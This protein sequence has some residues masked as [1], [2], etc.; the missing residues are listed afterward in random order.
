M[1]CF[2]FERLLTLIPRFKDLNSTI[3][4]S[5]ISYRYFYLT[6][7]L[8]LR[9]RKTARERDIRNS[10]YLNDY[11]TKSHLVLVN[12]YLPRMASIY[13][14]PNWRGKHRMF[15]FR[16]C[17]CFAFKEDGCYEIDQGSQTGISRA[18][19]GPLT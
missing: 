5:F 11:W 10:S 19:C 4:F 18:A 15:L 2:N 7:F 6:F 3:S 16:C 14:N 17:C 9:S 8:C 13:Q 12:V 1:K